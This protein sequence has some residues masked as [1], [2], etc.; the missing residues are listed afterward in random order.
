V[1]SFDPGEIVNMRSGF[2]CIIHRI[3]V[4]NTSVDPKIISRSFD[5]WLTRVWF[6]S[7]AVLGFRRRCNDSNDNIYILLTKAFWCAKHHDI[8]GSKSK[9]QFRFS[10]VWRFGSIHIA[11]L[12]DLDGCLEDSKRVGLLGDGIL[13]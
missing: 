9:R 12:H 3:P 4:I 2:L 11:Y 8:T 13:S 10:D 1:Y 7:L 5:P 6:H